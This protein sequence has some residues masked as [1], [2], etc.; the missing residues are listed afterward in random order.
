MEL[1]QNADD[2]KYT[3]V[4]HP[5]VPALVFEADENQIGI[6]CNEDGFT[7]RDV[8]AL[9]DVDQTTK[10][11]TNAIGKK[12]IGFK[13]VFKICDFVQIGSEGFQFSF[14]KTDRPFGMVK[15]TW[16]NFP[17]WLQDQQNTH[18]HLRFSA[19]QTFSDIHDELEN[20]EPSVLLFL[21]NL[22]EITISTNPSEY[23]RVLRCH[24]RGERY[25]SITT[26]SWVESLEL[27]SE[28]V[29]YFMVKHQPNLFR[30]KVVLAFP[31]SFEE[32][33]EPQNVHNFLPIRSYGFKV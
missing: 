10:N 23:R 5:H 17:K 18:M 6:R 27:E 7:T 4:Q 11:C 20:L 30:P 29:E 22:Q 25:T 9:C 8:E 21:R 14:D 1:I 28:S 24:N 32:T 12:G 31:C 15:P 26:E 3:R 16:R 19:G 13:S 33:I 2:A